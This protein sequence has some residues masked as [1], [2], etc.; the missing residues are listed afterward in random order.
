MS[1]NYERLMEDKINYT[2]ELLSRID[3]GIPISS[4]EL[5]EIFNTHKRIETKHLYN[6]RYYKGLES[7]IQIG[8]RFFVVQWH[9]GLVNDAPDHFRTQLLIEVELVED[10][11]VTKVWRRKKNNEVIYED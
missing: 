8:D 9:M 3:K 5:E 7:I 1:K 6:E 4:D 11:T 10:V 2:T